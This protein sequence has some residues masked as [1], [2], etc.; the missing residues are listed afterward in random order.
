M[1]HLESTL[2]IERCKDLKIPAVC[3]LYTTREHTLGCLK[4]NKLFSHDALAGCDGML[5][6]LLLGVVGE[7]MV[8]LLDNRLGV[9]GRL[10]FACCCC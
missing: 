4:K 6:F 2:F 3:V 5:L 10:L 1:Y 7:A 9:V 8:E